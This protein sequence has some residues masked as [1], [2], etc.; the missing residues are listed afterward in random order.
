[1]ARQLA[2]LLVGAGII[3]AVP[4]N[5]QDKEPP[6]PPENAMKL[7]QLIAT[8]EQRTDFRYVSDI[9]WNDDGFYEVTYFTSDK[10]KVEINLDAVTGKPR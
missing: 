8:V 2:A 7:S 5:A 1:M 9:E 10:A 6:I 4:A 3:V